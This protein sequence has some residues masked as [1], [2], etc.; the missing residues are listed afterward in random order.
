[1]FSNSDVVVRSSDKNSGGE[2][3]V[4]RTYRFYDIWPTNVASIQLSY[5]Q[6]GD[7]ERFDVEFAVQYFTV[8]DSPESTGGNRGE[9]RIN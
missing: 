7:I 8:G 9:E 2:V 6:T 4:L 3:S 5:D 1:M